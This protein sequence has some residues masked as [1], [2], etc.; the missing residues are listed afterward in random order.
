[1]ADA[2]ARCG[3]VQE[4]LAAQEELVDALA[5]T[6]RLALARFEQGV[7]GYLS[8]LDAQRS[9][10]AAEQALVY[11]RLAHMTSRVSLY[12]ALGGGWQPEPLAGTVSAP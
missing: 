6:H 3:T 5:E 12:A 9:L 10:F 7:D 4:Q 2:L 11:L 8:V 1:V